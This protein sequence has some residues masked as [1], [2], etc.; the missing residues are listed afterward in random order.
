M[1]KIKSKDVITT[2]TRTTRNTRYAHTKAL[3]ASAL[4]D[5]ASAFASSV[6][7][8]RLSFDSAG[9]G[10]CEVAGVEGRETSLEPDSLDILD[11]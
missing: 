10:G 9:D 2:H 7:S 6:I 5:A 8:C 4:N 11:V 1:S 3:L